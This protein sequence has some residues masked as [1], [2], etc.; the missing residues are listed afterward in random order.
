MQNTILV[1]L[2]RRIMS[3]SL[4]TADDTENLK[5][6]RNQNSS[7]TYFLF[8]G[9]PVGKGWLD[10]HSE[11]NDFRSDSDSKKGL[12]S[13]TKTSSTNNYNTKALLFAIYLEHIQIKINTELI[14]GESLEWLGMKTPLFTW[15]S[16]V[17]RPIFGSQGANRN[18]T[19]F[20]QRRLLSFSLSGQ[21][22]QK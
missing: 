12:Q 17:W 8:C 3:R 10:K 1:S 22:N 16:T 20:D 18:P 2:Q 9:S 21:I 6:M 7:T 13:S 15:Q 19:D 4:Y 14:R 5:Y 11:A